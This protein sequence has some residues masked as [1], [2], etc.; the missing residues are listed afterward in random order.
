[1]HQIS[2]P[3]RAFYV[4]THLLFLLVGLYCLWPARALAADCQPAPG[5]LLIWAAYIDT[6]LPADSPLAGNDELDEAIAVINMGDDTIDLAG[7]ALSDK[8]NHQATFPSY[9]LPSHA[10]VWAARDG[11]MYKTMFGVWPTFAY[12]GAAPTTDA[13]S[14]GVQPMTLTGSVTGPLALSNGTE[15]IKLTAADGALLDVL[16]YGKSNRYIDPAQWPQAG[17]VAPTA[18]YGPLVNNIPRYS[19]FQIISRKIDACTGL[20]VADTNSIADWA[21]DP[22]DDIAGRRFFRPGQD[23]PL[24]ATTLKVTEPV[25]KLKFLVS[26]D[27]SYPEFY[28]EIEAAQQSI[29][30]GGYEYAHPD[31]ITLLLE[32]SATL[33]VQILFERTPVEGLDPE[34]KYLCQ[35]LAARTNGSGCDWIDDSFATSGPTQRLIGRYRFHHAKYTIIDDKVVMVGT[36]NPNRSSIPYETKPANGASGNRGVYIVTDAPTVVQ[37]FVTLF[38]NDNDP[39][40]HFDVRAWDSAIITD[41]PPSDFVL[42]RLG[43][44]DRTGY[45]IVKP[46]ALSL[47]AGEYEFEVLQSPDNALAACTKP[48]A[49]RGLLG[50]VARAGAGDWV[51]AAQNTEE[52][53]WG[54]SSTPRDNPR[55]LAYIAAAQRGA[56]V[57][58]ILDGNRSNQSTCD[59]IN[60]QSIAGGGTIACLKGNPTGGTYHIKEVAVCAGGQ[61]YV[62]ISSIN[63]TENANKQNR[64]TGLQVTSTEAFVYMADLFAADWA[65][66]GGAP[67]AISCVA[68]DAPAS[69][70]ATPPPTATPLPTATPTTTP[71]STPPAPRDDLTKIRGIGPTYAS[72]LYAAGITTFAALAQLTPAEIRAVAAPGR[73]GNFIDAE[74]WITQAETLAHAQQ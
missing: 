61:G 50:M 2:L 45:T 65:I 53:P 63:G 1:M 71:T 23:L 3:R 52:Q 14:N 43:G 10:V 21:T 12:D 54:T 32:K 31:I 67:L 39:V 30:I 19:L 74:S 17:G 6:W 29:K 13:Q 72:R 62:N 70:T 60:N 73:A 69:A 28:A 58:V 66:L 68:T 7:C 35:E 55:L 42:P 34:Q 25:T 5:Q 20:P 18:G 26:P 56:T 64:E 22:E 38:A 8:T 48:G 4:L 44:A 49:D 36:E 11:A 46:E 47:P 40:N 24:Y 59:F 51:L 37:H 27:N 9:L 15:T 16:P 33:P 41:T 57:R